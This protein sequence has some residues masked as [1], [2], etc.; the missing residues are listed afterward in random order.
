MRSASA[1]C[2]DGSSTTGLTVA[3]NRSVS[4]T[5]LFVQMASTDSG[6]STNPST[7][8]TAEPTEAHRTERRAR[9]VG[10]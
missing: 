8:R 7:S 2:T 4:E 3:T 9:T 10:A 6:T 5:W 1:V